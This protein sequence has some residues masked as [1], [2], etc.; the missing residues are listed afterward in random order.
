MPSRASLLVADSDT[1]RRTETAERLRAAGYAVREAA[2]A[3]TARAAAA[4]ATT[5]AAVVDARLAGGGVE[6]MRALRGDAK[7]A[8]VRILLTV[9]PADQT[10]QGRAQYAAADACLVRPFD[11]RALAATVR[12]LEAEADLV[13]RADDDDGDLAGFFEA[14]EARAQA[15]NPLLAEL[16]DPVTGL[17]NGAYTDI[18]LAEEFK[19]ARRFRTSL[20]CV[21]LAADVPFPNTS[22]GRSDRRRLMSEL[23]G[24]LLCESRDV[25]HLARLDDDRFV[26]LLPQTDSAGAVAMA[27]RVAASIEKR[28]FRVP[29]H[30][31]PVTISAGVATLGLDEVG[32]PDELI[33]Q[34]NEALD[35]SRRHGVSRVT[36]WSPAPATAG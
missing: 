24:L 10:P 34:A 4:A 31:A 23:S 32:T 5:F 20:S 17:W 21:V 14:A 35:R 22:K 2:D 33:A 36:A 12:T 7:T 16:T 25:D 15:E 11:A 8:G 6:L 19:R 27:A 18:K 1:D 26:A 28:A 13:S 9:D 29:H 3:E 30:G